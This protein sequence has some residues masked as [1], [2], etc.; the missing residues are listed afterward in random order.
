MFKRITAY[1]ITLFGVLTLGSAAGTL[2]Q[3]ASKSSSQRPVPARNA[4]P[5]APV[6]NPYAEA[7]KLLTRGDDTNKDRQALQ[8]L[9]G[10]ATAGNA[11]YETLW[12]LSRAYY[13]VG[14]F[15]P[16][17]QKLAYF[18]KG[19]DAA[20]RAVA[21]QPNSV[22]GQFWLA[23]NYG[24]QGELVG[25]FKAMSLVKKI[26]A[27]MQ[28]VLQLNSSY[29]EGAAYLALGEIERELPYIAGG[30]KK[31]AI[32]Y[33]EQGLKMFPGNFEMKVALGKAYSEV[34]RKEDS[35]KILQEVLQAQA[36]N[37]GQ[38]DAQDEARKLLG[39]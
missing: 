24:G 12:R 17:A 34:G 22:D 4:A 32:S 8:L 9:E 11:G 26:R 38:R 14:D 25:V 23:A 36:R 39:K 18:Q 13:F 31:K 30:D 35:R 16:Q 29:E 10:L 37:R 5:A 1:V 6:R 7:D 21:L 20:S 2:A 15:A 19:A 27:G 33:F 28:L 3:P